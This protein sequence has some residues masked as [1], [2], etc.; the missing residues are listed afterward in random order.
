M[1]ATTL[2]RKRAR[3]ISPALVGGFVL[4]GLILGVLAI[5]LFSGSRFFAPVTRAVIFFP[6]SIS[7]LSV[8][9]PVT[10]RGVRIGSVQR[11]ALLLDARDLHA[12]IPVYVELEPDEVLLVGRQGGARTIELQRLVDAGLRAQL[13]M[14][15]FVTGQLQIDLDFLP[16]TPAQ[17]TGF[18]TGVTEIPAIPSELQQLK[19]QLN[20]LPLHDLVDQTNRTLRAI[21]L[22]AGD[23]DHRI[24]P[25]SDSV[26]ATS[27]STRATMEAARQA[28]ITLQQDISAT[29]RDTDQLVN[30]GRRQIAA[31]GAQIDRLLSSADR[32]AR[33]AE[34]ATTTLNGMI[35]LRS[36]ERSDFAATLRDLAATASSLRSFASE[37]E[38]NPSLILR[39]QASR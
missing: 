27:D 22:L 15:S 6:D 24:G 8:G 12:L 34:T 38:R 14:Q 26:L 35:S 13:A 2:G 28:V 18:V 32:V 3:A 33:D 11:I 23:F 20:G 21:E 30:D 7:G 25:L 37:I 10:F 29:A 39:G 36:S 9:D 17:R 31:S 1:S 19:N 5:L 4:G 16:G